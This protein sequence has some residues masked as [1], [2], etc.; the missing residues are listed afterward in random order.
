MTKTIKTCQ[1]QDKSPN[2]EI[3]S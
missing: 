1:N 2:Y 3:K